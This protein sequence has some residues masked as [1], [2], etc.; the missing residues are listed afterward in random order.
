MYRFSLVTTVLLAAGW[1]SVATN[2]TLTRAD[3]DWDKGN[4]IAALTAYRQ[5]L[6]GPDAAS[7]LEPIA[8][9]T[10]ELFLTTELT[11]DGANPAFAPNSRYFSYE[12]GPG[13]VAGVAAGGE[14]QGSG[15]LGLGEG[16]GEMAPRVTSA[17]PQGP[18]PNQRS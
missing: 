10:G 8:L 15:G 16:G 9:Q 11:T 6:A 7:V 17:T 1:L 5:L 4:Y 2:P 3:D 13:V 14:R 12:T 18:I